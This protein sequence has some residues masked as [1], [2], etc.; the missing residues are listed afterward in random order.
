MDSKLLQFS[1][2]NILMHIE[3]YPGQLFLLTVPEIQ[4]SSSITV[5]SQS[6]LTIWLEQEN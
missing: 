6:Y 1:E 4:T 3:F 5:V 2:K